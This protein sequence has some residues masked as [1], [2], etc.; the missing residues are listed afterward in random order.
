MPKRAFRVSGRLGAKPCLGV[1][2]A[3]CL[4]AGCASGPPLITQ[5]TIPL[6]GF[7]VPFPNLFFF[8]HSEN[9]LQHL[10]YTDAFE[11]MHQRLS[12]AYPYTEWKGVDWDALHAEYAPRVAA[13]E[14]E[15]D[16][17]AWYTA[18]RSYLHAVPD[19]QVSI[20]RDP[21][22]Y[23]EDVGGG[24]GLALSEL[25]DG[26]VLIHLLTPEGPAEGVGI[27]WGAEVIS[28]NGQPIGE[29]MEEVSLLW[30]SEPPVTPRDRRLAQ[31]R[32][33][34]RAP[35]GM[36]AVVGV[37]QPGLEDT[38]AM[39]AVDDGF[40]TLENAE[41]FGHELDEFDAPISARYLASGHAY[42]RLYVMA[43]TLSVPFPER[44]FSEAILGFVNA[45]APGMVLDL[46]GNRGGVD[47][48]VP[49]LLGHFYEEERFYADVET[50]DARRGAFT[51]ERNLR[52][53]IEPRAPLFAAPIV[54]L[55]DAHTLGPAEGMA[56]TLQALPHVRV[57]GF[58]P[59]RGAAGI[60]GGTVI[61]PEGYTVSYPTGRP[62]D[63]TGAPLWASGVTR[64]GGVQPDIR[65]PF[66]E[67]ALHALYMEGRDP[68]IAAAVEALETAW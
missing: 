56:A 20:Q 41:L 66:D 7:A 52:L 64:E 28:W 36:T 4:F 43:P 2:L 49:K 8:L 34:A 37:R 47:D 51:V 38:R 57:L 40:Q 32:L 39:D 35:E 33:R 25:D 10:S 16:V 65:V 17:H 68:L 44:A 62:V 53:N 59:S 9:D 5:Y 12:V 24:F 58:E 11:A 6:T 54:I 15:A 46:R 50:Y 19:A 27:Q 31:L 30:A 26:R 23:A 61:L 3:L 22:F 29:A 63:E 60:A 14:T 18:V 67:A 21:E 13:A 55:V 1:A 42:L 48:L 45:G